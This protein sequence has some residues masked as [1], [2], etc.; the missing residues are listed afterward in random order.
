MPHSAP[1]ALLGLTLCAS[2]TACKDK[3]DED[4]SAPPPIQITDGTPEECTGSAPVITDLSCENTGIQDHFETL[5]PTVT[6]AIRVKAEDEDGD[7][8][9]YGLEI[10]YDDV[11]DDAIDTS[12]VQFNPLSGSLDTTEC[13][14][15]AANVGT[16]MYLT[17]GDP[18]YNT[19][20]EWGVIVT[21]AHGLSSEL[22]TT[23]CVT[24][25]SDGTDGDGAGR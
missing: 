13:G 22:V 8:H 5:E 12:V 19:V 16:T 21:D 14:A 15:T 7:L 2:L 11:V 23:A 17:G 18:A 9:Q 25:Q 10:F 4:S 1:L 3:G 6:M 20:Y 24:P